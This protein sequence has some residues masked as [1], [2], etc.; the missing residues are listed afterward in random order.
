MPEG[1]GLRHR[2]ALGI[3][4]Q[5]DAI[6]VIISEQTGSLSIAHDSRLLYNLAAD[7]FDH[8]LMHFFGLDHRKKKR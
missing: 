2:S 7:L 8:K 4:E 3:A 5:T 6:A 1:T